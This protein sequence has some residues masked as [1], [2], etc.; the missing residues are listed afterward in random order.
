MEATAQWAQAKVYPQDGSYPASLDAL[1]REPYRSMPSD[2]RAYAS[3]IFATFLEQKVANSDVIVRQTWERYRANNGGRMLTAIDQ[4][5]RNQYN[6]TIANAFPNF[7]WHNYFMNNGTYDLQVTNVY[8]NTNPT[9]LPPAFT[10]PQ[11]QLF[12][13]HLREGRDNWQAGHAG[14]WVDRVNIFPAN[15]NS[16]TSTYSSR[17]ENLGA[18]FIEFVPNPSLSATA[19]LSVT[20]TV[21]LPLLDTTRL[22]RVS[23]L[24]ISNFAAVPHPGNVFLTP[25]AAPPPTP[26]T[27]HYTFRVANFRQCD[28]VTLIANA[29]T[30]TADLF[31]YRYLAEVITPSNPPSPSP[32]LLVVP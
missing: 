11:W 19:V 28:R 31:D 13:S 14:V 3:F 32:C 24:P 5:L 6:T 17:V 18:A 23:V 22:A 4:T 10:G 8:T 20:F 25:R 21:H 29:I 1:L 30:T 15:S 27:S 26:L 12:R 16:I 7:T 2:A 9:T